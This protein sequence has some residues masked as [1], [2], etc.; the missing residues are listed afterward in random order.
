MIFKRKFDLKTTQQLILDGWQVYG[1]RRSAYRNGEI[2]TPA[3]YQ[4]QLKERSGQQK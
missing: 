3:I 2:I 4:R 1:D